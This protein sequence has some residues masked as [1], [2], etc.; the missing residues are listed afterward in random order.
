MRREFL[1]PADAHHPDPDEARR[2]ILRD[3]H[4]GL[5]PSLA[6]VVFG[7]RAARNLVAHDPSSAQRLLARLEGEMHAAIGEIRRL[8]ASAYPSVLARSGLAEAVRAYGATLAGRLPAGDD[9]EVVI[10][11]DLGELPPAVEVAAYRII[12]EALTNV[13]NHAGAHR[14]VVRVWLDGDLHVE[15][16]DDGVWLAPRG[17]GGVGLRSM[18]DRAQELGGT[19]V[20]ER[21]SC[22]GT[23]VAVDLPV[24]SGM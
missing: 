16:V 3:L 18:R 9:I 22:G 2:R 8:A 14:C 1:V 11:G 17:S 12:C 21:R 23:R 13:A 15:V 6:A 4:D 20:V 19:W 7:L 10:H 24:A 5:G